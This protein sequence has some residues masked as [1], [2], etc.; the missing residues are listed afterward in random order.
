VL[1]T[2]LMCVVA[3]QAEKIDNPEYQ[4]W[5]KFK[6]GA[7]ATVEMVNKMGDTESKVRTT[8]TL[9]SI[10]DDKAVVS[11]LQVMEVGEQEIKQT[12]ERTIP[13]KVDKPEEP[14]EED[15]PDVKKGDETIKVKAGTFKCETVETHMQKDDQ[16]IVTKVWTCPKVP[17]GMVKMTMRSSGKM[18]MTT[19]SELV[20]VKA[21]GK[22]ED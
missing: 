17:G 19:E 14:A 15:K 8:T 12:T 5:A 6:A 2:V 10:D 11:T 21:E 22:D 9:K 20:E 3:A 7:S 1:L 13:A 16:K 4:Q 18:S